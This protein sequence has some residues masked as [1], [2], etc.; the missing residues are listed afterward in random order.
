MDTL[1]TMR[2]F[3]AVAAEGS[4]TRGADRLGIAVQTAS[5]YVRQ[6]EGRLGAPLF[7]RNTRS[8]KLNDTGRAYLERCLDLLDQ[9][10]ELEASVQSEHHT[11]KGRIR[12]TAPTNFGERYLVP[13]IGRFLAEHPDVSVDLT[14]TGRRVGLVEEGF[15]LA[16]RIGQPQ[17]STLVARRL[18]PMRVVVCASPEYLD[19]HGRPQDPRE[20]SEHRCA[21]DT[22]FR[23][24]RQ[25]LF[26]IGDETVRVPVDGPLQA[27]SPAATRRMALTGL[28]IA[29]CPHYVVSADVVA[30]RLEILFAENEAFEFGVHALYPHRRHLSTRVR[31]LVDH[32]A[33]EFRR[34]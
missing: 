9:F 28:A 21:I 26:R 12:V 19:A 22:N 30:G 27:N 17:D 7:D 3:A 29:R 8:V 25:W 4:F 16:V 34:M 5:K 15:D 14:L 20:L 1:E 10:D 31:G 13:S 32:L 6:L 2:T 24:D 33:Q 18:A 23:N 11:L